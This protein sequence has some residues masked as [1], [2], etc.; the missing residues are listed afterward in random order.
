MTVF[1]AN[2]KMGVSRKIPLI[3]LLEHTSEEWKLVI[4]EEGILI[5]RVKFWVLGFP[6]ICIVCVFEAFFYHYFKFL[7]V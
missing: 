4:M 1:N 2:L 6:W 7:F 5:K 3:N